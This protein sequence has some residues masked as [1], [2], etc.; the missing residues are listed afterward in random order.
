[1]PTFLREDENFNQENINASQ[2][3]EVQEFI[4]I[5]KSRKITFGK[6]ISLFIML[7]GL[8]LLGSFIFGYSLINK[9]QGFLGQGSGQDL[10]SQLGNMSSIFNLKNREQLQGESQGRT[11]FLLVGKDATGSGLTDTIM[12]VS[13][14]YEEEKFVSVNIP[15]DLF[16]TDD[17]GSY[18]INSLAAFAQGRGETNGE[19]YLVDFL[20]K[21]F[22]IPIHYWASVSF[23]GVTQLVDTLGG[24]E[25]DVPNG[26]SDFQYPAANYNGYLKP[27]PVFEQGIT[28][29]D[30]KTALIYARSRNGNNNEGSDFARGK[31]Q[32]I[33]IEAILNK[34]QKQKLLNNATKINSYLDILQNNFLTSMNLSE[35]TSFAKLIQDS[36]NIQGNFYRAVWET[37]NGFLCPSTSL[38]GAYIIGYCDG[39]FLGDNG[40]SMG[41]ERAKDFL[42]NLLEETLYSKLYESKIVILGNQSFD[43]QKAVDGFSDSGYPNIRTNNAFAKIAPATPSSVETTTI[44][45]AND[46]VKE[47]FLDN[48]NKPDFKYEV[49]NTPK[50]DIT[51]TYGE[52]D[53]LVVVE[54]QETPVTTKD[55]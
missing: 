21:E 12:L 47:M 14:Y 26:F 2:I 27:A 41:R 52:V 34:I 53:I 37:G 35:I 20:S 45:F 23:D 54:S 22:G 38:E 29:M 19:E 44:F 31:R 30:G 15:R 48:T 50:Y 1:M 55:R 33:V 28:T 9:S 13:Y 10:F 40:V 5:K 16:V 43:T 36:D 18:K 7:L 32:S 39:S 17:F 4:E 42:E 3:E 25:V 24:I 49:V 8:G 46:S 11:N 51:A 6:V